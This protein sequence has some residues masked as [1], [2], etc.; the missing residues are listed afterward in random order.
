MKSKLIFCWNRSESI[1]PVSWNLFIYLFFFSFLRS[2]VLSFRS[3]SYDKFIVFSKENSPQGA[4]QCFL[5]LNFQHSPLSLEN[6]LLI[7]KTILKP[8]WTYGI[9]LWGCANKSNIAIMQRYQSKLLRTIINTSWYVTNNTLHTD[10]H[11]PYV[12][13]VIHDRI[14]KHRTILASHPNPLMEPLLQPA[15]NRRLQRRW[16]FDWTDWGGIGGCS[17]RSPTTMPAH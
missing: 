6:K 16:T 12:H 14:N 8:V 7:Y 11:V 17:L 15:H 4:I 5:P 9:E 2:F 10:L 3:L 1:N 13:T